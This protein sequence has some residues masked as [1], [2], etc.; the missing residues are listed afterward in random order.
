MPAAASV[1]V[2]RL[3]TAIVLAYMQSATEFINEQ[4]AP[5][6]PVDKEHDLVGKYD[7][8]TFFRRPSVRGIL[9]A[10]GAKYVRADFKLTTDNFIAQEY[11]VEFALD[12]R[13]AALADPAYDLS[14]TPTQMLTLNVLRE[15]EIRVK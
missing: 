2:D 4:I 11:G 5:P 7:K 13:T 8:S 14:N 6:I 10:P 15:R 3:L 1:H 12:S 9:R